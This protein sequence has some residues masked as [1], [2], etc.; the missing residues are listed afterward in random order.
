MRNYSEFPGELRGLIVDL[1]K[2]ILESRARLP[3]GHFSP[4]GSISI[5]RDFG[6]VRARLG[7][8]DGYG[9]HG[10]RGESRR[11]DGIIE[12][13]VSELVEFCVVLL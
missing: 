13:Y 11:M 1:N 7:W 5:F 2:R 12:W 3:F 9:E 6:H 4:V 10:S 8:W